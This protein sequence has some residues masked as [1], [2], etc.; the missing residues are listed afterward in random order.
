M[1][2]FEI[3]H[4]FYNYRNLGLP[5]YDLEITDKNYRQLFA[6]LPNPRD[7]ILTEEYKDYVRAKFFH[8]G[9]E[10]KVRVRF[11]GLTPNH[12]EDEKKSWR[13]RFEKGDLFEGKRS[14]NLVIPQDRGYLSEHL[15]NY[16]ARKMG[17][18]VPDSRYAFLRVNGQFQGIYFEIEQPSGKEFLERNK[19]K[20]DANF[21][22]EENWNWF[23]YGFTPIFTKLAH[24]KKKDR[25]AVSQV[26]NYAELDYLLFLLNE[27]DDERF[28]KEIPNLMDIG[29]FFRWQS[30]S[31][32]MGSYH[33]GDH[34]NNNLYFDITQGKFEPMP[35]D[36]HQWPI[37]GLFFDKPYNPLVTRILRN[38]D[39]LHERNRI[40]WGYVN[41][42]KNLTD[43]VAFYDDI[44]KKTR[45][46]FYADRKKGVM[47]WKFDR[48]VRRNR[49][50][51]VTNWEKIRNNLSF[52]TLFAHVRLFPQQEISSK[53]KELKV[54]AIL[55]LVSHGFSAARLTGVKVIFGEGEETSN[56]EALSLYQDENRN[57]ILDPK[58]RLVARFAFDPKV[59]G[60]N[61]DNLGLILHAARDA[62]LQPAGKNHRLFLVGAP[63]GLP[64]R[65]A[66]VEV[67]VRAENGVTGEAVK[68]E[69][70][71]VDARTLARFNEIAASPDDFAMRYPFFQR[72]ADKANHFFLPAREFRLTQTVIVPKGI[73]I[74][75]SP[76]ATLRF[77]S[78]VSFISYGRVRAVGKKG[79]PIVFTAADKSHPWGVFAV[80]GEH[81]GG[82]HFEYV[83]VE[84]GS[85]D[86]VNG[87]FF[88]GA[89][90]A[91]SA[92]VHVEHSIFRYNKGDDGLN[93]K[94]AAATVL[95]SLFYENHAD[96]LDV[97]TSAAKI[98][99][100]QF[101]N[102][103]NDA[104][105]IGDFASPRIIGNWIEG[106]KDKGI[107][108]GEHSMALIV[109]NLILRCNVGIAIKDLSEATVVNNTIMANVDAI[110]AYK[111]KEMFG[112][113]KGIVQNTLIWGNK[114]AI[115]V[116]KF[117]Q[118][119][120]S[121]SL[122]QGGYKGENIITT[123]PQFVAPSEGDYRLSQVGSNT[124]LLQGGSPQYLLDLFPQMKGRQV[125]MGIVSLPER[126]SLAL[127]KRR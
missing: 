82:S 125:P 89:L 1:T 22:N 115:N 18:V 78:K 16:R 73:E 121:H 116:D 77:D 11:R 56:K 42:P 31:M 98:V 35:W 126:N 17:L 96:G 120:V 65:T 20:G 113:G 68:P 107:S 19:R 59:K 51:I 27:A 81:A 24:W 72:G 9:K 85:E 87:A 58:D 36:V 119:T 50:T 105:D 48:E 7:S 40:L 46:G 111:K 52:S 60:Y 97:D 62:D 127:L 91:Y 93:I 124:Q 117:S 45:R 10:Y 34:N 43:D 104:I 101:V 103:G 25:D 118:V 88:S 110:S 106:S 53:L 54:L 80:L 39:F 86:Y 49:E 83:I 63:R 108:V 76:G 84:Y 21:Y 41:N 109:N 74:S 112:G 4:L 102:N 57:G 79:L 61:A 6:N 44:Y 114:G 29:Q 38:P 26:D 3:S 122:V 123:E 30:H 99:E 32:L 2:R 94:G 47:N 66:P 95:Q 37:K 75:I 100:N 23:R 15:A 55:D 67:Q 28:H 70:R 92:P 64:D 69:I 71:Y 33:Q 13:I 8:Q 14:I 90:S 12:W 5:I